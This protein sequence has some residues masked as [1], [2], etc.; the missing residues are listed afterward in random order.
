MKKVLGK[1]LIALFI[2]AFVVSM[3]YAVSSVSTGYPK[4]YKF[5]ATVSARVW[6]FAAPGYKNA[7]V[8]CTLSTVDAAGL[9]NWALW[10]RRSTETAGL[11]DSAHAT[12]YRDVSFDGTN[13]VTLDTM[14]VAGKTADTLGVFIYFRNTSL[15]LADTTKIAAGYNQ[16]TRWREKTG[17]G[18]AIYLRIRMIPNN[19]ANCST[20][21]H[22]PKLFAEP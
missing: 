18:S 8:L 20:Y 5:P 9:H 3:V 16:P 19:A 10:L 7:T 4:D 13:F 17:W 12:I 2:S 22:A 14:D 1:V 11:C 15:E 6:S 21:F